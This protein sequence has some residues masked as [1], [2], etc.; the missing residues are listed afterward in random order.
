MMYGCDS[1]EFGC[2]V[3][4]SPSTRGSKYV[5]ARFVRFVRSR[6]H[7][8][9]P[10]CGPC[11]VAYALDVQIDLIGHFTIKESQNMVVPYILSLC[12]LHVPTFTLTINRS[13]KFA[14]A[15]LI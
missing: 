4:T 7:F 5:E 2:K 13:T 15:N 8:Q 3:A 1:A 9:R 11:N 10:T 12:P 6:T 14:S